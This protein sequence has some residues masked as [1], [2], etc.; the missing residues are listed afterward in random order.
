MP[1]SCIDPCRLPIHKAAISDLI[2]M[3]NNTKTTFGVKLSETS[4]LPPL[5]ILW[6][7]ENLELCLVYLP[8]FHEDSLFVD[9][10]S[11]VF[12]VLNL[13]N[14]DN[15][16]AQCL[17]FF[18]EELKWT[19]RRI[20]PHS[21]GCE[22]AFNTLFQLDA[23]DEILKSELFKSS[24]LTRRFRSQLGFSTID[25][26]GPRYLSLQEMISGAGKF[27]FGMCFTLIIYYIMVQANI[28]PEQVS[29]ES[30]VTRF[31][32]LMNITDKEEGIKIVKEITKFHADLVKELTKYSEENKTKWGDTRE[33]FKMP[34]PILK[35]VEVERY[36]PISGK[37][38][39][40][41]KKAKHTIHDWQVISAGG[42]R[43]SKP[44]RK[45]KSK[46]K[47]KFIKK[48]KRL[49]KRRKNFKRKS[50]RKKKSRRRR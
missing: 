18:R 26:K 43:K 16:H 6:D 1:E 10:K 24:F 39:R 7:A 45:S 30:P 37:G 42:K 9:G 32:R 41:S 46:R 33:A 22:G 11:N 20:E 28:E 44:K 48:S 21:I 8:E 29:D 34:I 14:G 49:T 17:H 25:Y 5:V 2:N 36:E 40:P 15:E 50:S 23:L 31:H 27:P 13:K 19:F 12:Y 38:E 3:G 4:F 47:S 35:A